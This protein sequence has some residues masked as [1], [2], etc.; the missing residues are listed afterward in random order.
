M[1]EII[2]SKQDLQRIDQIASK[3]PHALLVIAGY[4]LDGKNVAQKI[5]K[6]SDIFQLK[7]LPD[8][9]TISVEQIR[10]L[11]IKLRTY[12]INR[13]T[14]I[15]D[16]ADLMTESSQ[17][18]LLKILEEP[19]KNT[20]FILIVA[21]QK[22]LLD[23]IKSRCQT[24]TLHKTS[25]VEDRKLLEKYNLDPSTNQQILFLAAGRPLLIQQ[26]ARNPKKFAE[27]RQLATDAKH[28]LVSPRQ[29]SALKSLA[30]YF[31]DCQKALLLTDIIINM[32]RFQAL[33]H[34][35]NHQFEEQLS[36]T[37]TV[38][39]ALRSNANIKLSLTQLVL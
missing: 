26:L 3:P 11:I 12:A 29:Y 10:E 37:I 15:I 22:S 30:K 25:L 19:N 13:R 8:K 27:Y 14:I 1:S 33:S 16:S 35:M 32:I 9:Q 6:N 21:N 5:A 20:N 4:G 18:A 36:R 38:A 7:L 28:I 17:N 23:T 31:T 34:G 39:N 2:V 24:L